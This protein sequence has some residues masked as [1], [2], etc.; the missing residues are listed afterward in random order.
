VPS[1]G[2]L[3]KDREVIAGRVQHPHTDEWIDTAGT[4]DYRAQAG[5]LAFALL[6]RHAPGRLAALPAVVWRTWAPARCGLTRPR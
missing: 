3:L 5:Y 6:H 4:L 1:R 2:V